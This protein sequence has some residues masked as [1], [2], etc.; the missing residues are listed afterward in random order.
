MPGYPLDPPVTP[1]IRRH[2]LR[3][4]GDKRFLASDEIPSFTDSNIDIMRHSF[5]VDLQTDSSF[6]TVVSMTVNQD[7][8]K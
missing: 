6:Y 8:V 7:L 4:W 5:Y 3:N 1:A 2:F